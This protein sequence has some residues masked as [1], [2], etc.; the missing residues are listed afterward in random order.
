MGSEDS[1]ESFVAPDEKDEVAVTTTVVAE[2]T[3]EPED[4]EENSLPEEDQGSGAVG[5]SISSTSEAV[6]TTQLVDILIGAAAATTKSPAVTVEIESPTT[7]LIAE[8]VP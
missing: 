4:F 5:T 6:V 2:T 3:A 8:A 1:A 7:L